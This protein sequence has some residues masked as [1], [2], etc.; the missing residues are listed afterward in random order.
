MKY[1]V[2]LHDVTEGEDAKYDLTQYK[3][4]NLRCFASPPRKRVL[5][6]WCG[7][8]VVAAAKARQKIHVF[9]VIVLKKKGYVG[10]IN[11]F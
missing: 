5:P 3:S 2:L 7:I 6:Y 4:H 11:F 8:R 1:Y 9:T 10:T